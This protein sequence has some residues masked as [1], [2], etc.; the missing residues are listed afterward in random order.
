MSSLLWCA[1][2]QLPHPWPLAVHRG[3]HAQSQVPITSFVFRQKLR[4]LFFPPDSSA[5]ID[6]LVG[7]LSFVP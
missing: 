1:I 7:M 6:F 5:C 3:W 2:G 4:K